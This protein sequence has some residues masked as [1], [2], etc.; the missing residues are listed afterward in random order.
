MNVTTPSAAAARPSLVRRPSAQLMSPRDYAHWR[1]AFD[2]QLAGFFNERSRSSRTLALEL[3]G[4]VES[5]L[6]GPDADLMLTALRAVARVN[7]R[8]G[9]AYAVLRA[10]RDEVPCAD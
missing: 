9:V 10:V 8:S 3:V 4:L 7:T 5:Y 1:D 6:H 2:E